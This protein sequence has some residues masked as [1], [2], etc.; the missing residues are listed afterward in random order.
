MNRLYKAEGNKAH[1]EMEPGYEAFLMLN[2]PEWPSDISF[3]LNDPTAFI[4]Y[5]NA[6]GGRGVLRID[7]KMVS[8]PRT[9]QIVKHFASDRDDFFRA[10]SSAFVKLSTS[11]SL[12]QGVFRKRCNVLD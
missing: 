1:Q 6:M 9:A 3:V 2:C 5:K 12:N 7:A 10:F 11:G 4:F 8:D